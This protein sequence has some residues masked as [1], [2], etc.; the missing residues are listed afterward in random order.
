MRLKNW[1]SPRNMGKRNDKSKQA[2]A[3]LRQLKK[4]DKMLTKKLKGE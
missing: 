2:S 1:E 3:R 4:R